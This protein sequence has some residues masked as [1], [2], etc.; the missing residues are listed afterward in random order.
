MKKEPITNEKDI[1]C[2]FTCIYVS[3][4]KDRGQP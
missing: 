3:L 1:Q 4:P 2:T